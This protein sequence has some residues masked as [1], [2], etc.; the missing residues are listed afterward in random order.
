MLGKKALAM[1]GVLVVLGATVG[2]VTANAY[3]KNE[4]P[5]VWYGEDTETQGLSLVGGLGAYAS[6]TFYCAPYFNPQ[7]YTNPEHFSWAYGYGEIW[8]S[9][10]YDTLTAVE[11][12]TVGDVF[13][14]Y[15]RV[16]AS[17][18]FPPNST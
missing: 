2:F 11:T 9:E 5:G 8:F 10:F 18:G 12:V 3:W 6:A 15:F 14:A 4:G 17:V 13:G 16:Y 1:L 7:Y